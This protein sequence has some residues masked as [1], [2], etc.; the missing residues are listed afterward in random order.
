MKIGRCVGRGTQKENFGVHRW[1]SNPL[2]SEHWSDALTTELLRTRVVSMVNEHIH[3]TAFP[4]GG[5][6]K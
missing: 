1:D 3:L 5:E 4:H 2:S 6:E